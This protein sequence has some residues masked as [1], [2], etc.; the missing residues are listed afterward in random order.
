M[1]GWMDGSCDGEMDGQTY[2]RLC[3]AKAG[4]DLPSQQG[5]EPSF[6]LLFRPI[7]HQH[8]HVACIW[9]TTVEHLEIN[10]SNKNLWMFLPS[11]PGN[12]SFH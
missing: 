12:E 5:F 4:A 6:L 8:L 9:S 7:P 10:F 1:D 2:M 3:H 11:G